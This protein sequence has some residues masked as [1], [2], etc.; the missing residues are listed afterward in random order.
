MPT[1]ES[2]LRTLQGRHGAAV[3]WNKP[4]QAE[5][6]RDLAAEK[7]ATY[8]SQIVDAAP[9]LTAAQRDRIAALLRSTYEPPGAVTHPSIRRNGVAEDTKAQPRLEGHE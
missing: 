8:V 5:T 6:A 9:P 3:R 1:D 7:I 4:N 2:R